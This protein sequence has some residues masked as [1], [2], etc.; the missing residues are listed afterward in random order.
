MTQ[1]SRPMLIALVGTLAFAAVWFTVLRPSSSTTETSAPAATPASDAASGAA[2]AATPSSDATPG[3]G[4]TENVEKAQQAA[5]TANGKIASDAAQ[6][7]AVGDAA[8]ATGQAGQQAQADAAASSGST[9]SAGAGS[10]GQG[11]T[12]KITVDTQAPAAERAVLQD[13]A[14]GKV[15]VML[16][17]DSK[18][19]DDREARR[20]VRAATS[21]RKNV[22]VKV[23]PVK[24][25]GAY[26]SITGG[27]TIERSPTTLIMGPAMKAVTISGLVDELEIEQAI[28]RMSAKK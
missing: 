25:V 15:V 20:A 2:P 24:D 26:E 19:A 6:A 28:A 8:P 1:V 14:S 11:A 23:V 13:L 10:G 3:V 12:A 4:V 5:D 16:F 27:V 7:N 21:G 22:A 18:A 9:G 17:W